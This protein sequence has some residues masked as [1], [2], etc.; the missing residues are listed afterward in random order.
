MCVGL[1]S[2]G[3]D[4]NSPKHMPTNRPTGWMYAYRLLNKPYIYNQLLREGGYSISGGGDWIIYPR[5]ISTGRGLMA[6]WQFQICLGL[7]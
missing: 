3:I 2:T 1:D 5:I 6:R 4:Y 7:V